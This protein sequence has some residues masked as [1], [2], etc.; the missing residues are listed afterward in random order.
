[1]SSKDQ[2]IYQKEKMR[3]MGESWYAKDNKYI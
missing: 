1:M 3:A 2:K